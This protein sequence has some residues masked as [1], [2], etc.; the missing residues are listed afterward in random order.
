MRRRRLSH[1]LRRAT[2]ALRSGNIDAAQ[3]A[4]AEAAQ[5]DPFD[6]HV[7]QLESQ[8]ALA[9]L[10]RGAAPDSI[11]DLSQSFEDRSTDDFSGPPSERELFRAVD[12][13]SPR[14]WM[15]AAAVLILL[16][17][18]AGWYWIRDVDRG[19]SRASSRS[20]ESG[21]QARNE[22]EAAEDESQSVKAP[23]E[24]G[25]LTEDRSTSSTGRDREGASNQQIEPLRNRVGA[26]EDR[27]GSAIDVAAAGPEAKPERRE[28][29]SVDGTYG[30]D[31]NERSTPRE[32]PAET[33]LESSLAVVPNLPGAEAG[34]LPPERASFD[35][36]DPT[37]AFQ[38]GPS[39]D[40]EHSAAAMMSA[41][42]SVE[43][44]LRRYEEASRRLDARAVS[45]VWPSVNRE[46]LARSFGALE[47]LRFTLDNCRVRV[48]G[49]TA[50]ADCSGNAEWQPRNGGSQQSAQR[51]WRFDLK[52]AGAD[53]VITRA[54]VR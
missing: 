46:T 43:V 26:R 25:R 34:A 51:Q 30:G 2:G 17:G 12:A 11:A 48:T 5:L 27:T 20:L 21:A 40:G 14:R 3:G 29:P 28:A 45:T 38:G 15:G 22:R 39:D 32:P 16:S 53:W 7:K 50:R 8:I 44:A 52:H 42:R 41:P 35:K 37:T 33:V 13:S 36:S 10:G 4:L 9:R 24:T 54:S 19:S 31:A 23:S 1:C 49:D 47:S 6:R 18:A